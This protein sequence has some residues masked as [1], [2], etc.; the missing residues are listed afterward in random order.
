MTDQP[1]YPSYPGPEGQP[2]PPPGYH[3]PP[4]PGYHA[5][6][7]AYPYA[8]WWIRVGAQILDMLIAFVI[9]IVPIGVGV[10]LAFR[11]AETDPVTDEITG[12]V[13]PVGIVLMILG[14]VAWLAF[15]IWNRGVRVGRRGQ[16]LGKQAVGIAVIRNADGGYLGAG[17]GFLRWLIALF[18]N[19]V[20]CAGIV[21]VLWPLWD[22]RKQTLHDKAVGSV[23]VRR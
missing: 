22:S 8:G 12:G 13:E 16:S 11:D 10:Y 15:E 20:P 5:P 21:D 23:S 18:I 14:I 6:P 17:M 2:P 19:W 3:P 1:Q 4:P 7:P 9:A